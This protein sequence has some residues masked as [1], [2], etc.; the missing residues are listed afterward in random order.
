[1]IRTPSSTR[2]RGRLFIIKV[3]AG[4]ADR[5]ARGDEL[6]GATAQGERSGE[7]CGWTCVGG[8]GGLRAEPGAFEADGV[9]GGVS[10]VVRQSLPFS[11]LGLKLTQRN[12]ETRWM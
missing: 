8:G 4:S 11:F 2:Q 5:G 3:T 1:V 10:W 7:F 9:G 12:F 6:G